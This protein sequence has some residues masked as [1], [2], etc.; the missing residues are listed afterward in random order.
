LSVLSHYFQVLT[1][2]AGELDWRCHVI[3]ARAIRAK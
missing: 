1:D 3:F 2:K